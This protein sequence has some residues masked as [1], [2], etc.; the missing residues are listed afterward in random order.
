[1]ARLGTARRIGADGVPVDGTGFEYE[2][3]GKIAELLAQRVFPI[4]SQPTTGEFIFGLATAD[5]TGGLYER[6]AGVF[7]SGN[8]GPPEHFHPT[9]D[10]HFEV[11]Q[12]EFIFR[13]AGKERTLRA[14]DSVLVSKGMPHTFRCISEGF[15]AAVVETR[16]A[17]RITAVLT[18]LFGMAHEGK[19]S[20]A[21]QPKMLH[22]MVIA[23]EYAD[24]TVFTNPPPAIAI[25]LARAIAP[26]ARALGYRA[27]DA[28]YMNPE[29][30][31]AHV[32][33]P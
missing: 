23:S 20:A 26:L 3:D 11:I 32:E 29:F 22:A 15:G 9:Y 18:T 17:A 12:G 33:Q 4:I 28:R 10:E 24:D 25:P 14:G 30:W 7:P 31:R 2:S 13:L 1:M 5:Q 21:G 8:A 16:P 6:G 19:L 27:D